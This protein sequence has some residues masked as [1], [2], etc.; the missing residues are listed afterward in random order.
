VSVAA[1]HTSEADFERAILD[2]WPRLEDPRTGA[3]ALAHCDAA[4]AAYPRCA[5]FH[6]MRGDL[7][8]LVDDVD[9][10]LP[11]EES[12]RCYETALAID[13]HNEEAWFELG[14]FWDVVMANPRKARQYLHKAF[15]LRRARERAA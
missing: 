4:L 7:L 10:P 14:M 3:S 13:P 1:P 15:L 8:Q 12:M 5:R 2:A 9:P 6:V 11:L